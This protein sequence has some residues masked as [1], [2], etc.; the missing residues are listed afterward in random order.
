MTVAELK[1]QN[2]FVRAEARSNI[3]LSLLLQNKSSRHPNPFLLDNGHE[4]RVWCADQEKRQIL[5]QLGLTMLTRS[6]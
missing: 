6:Q 2:N 4:V 5:I 1:L 3:P